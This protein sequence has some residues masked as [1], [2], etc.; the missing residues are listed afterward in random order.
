MPDSRSW[1]E[2]WRDP[3]E[4]FTT[5]HCKILSIPLGLS[6]PNY[7][8]EAYVAGL[9]AR[10]WSDYSECKVRV[11]LIPRPDQ[12][13]DSQLDDAGNILDLEIVIADRKERRMFAEHAEWER[14]RLRGE[15][16]LVLSSGEVETQQRQAQAREAISR[17]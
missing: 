14:M 11:R 1:F 7:L 10:I 13:P 6:V 4:F 8:G 2:C 15:I 12:F 5:A 3:P 16:P 9:F 17:V